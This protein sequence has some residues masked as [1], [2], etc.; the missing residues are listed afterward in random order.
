[1]AARAARDSTVRLAVLVYRGL[2][3]WLLN[4]AVSHARPMSLTRC[5]IALPNT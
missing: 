1:M 4:T 5:P 3:P 2:C